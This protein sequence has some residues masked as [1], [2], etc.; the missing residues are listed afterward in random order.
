MKTNIRKVPDTA[1]LNKSKITKRIFSLFIG[2][3]VI[4]IEYI[5]KQKEHLEII[6]ETSG[7]LNKFNPKI[8]YFLSSEATL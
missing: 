6:I 3:N 2:R 8:N 4:D 1:L 5:I 7:N